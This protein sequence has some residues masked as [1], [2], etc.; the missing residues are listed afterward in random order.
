VK[1]W[2]VGSYPKT[3]PKFWYPN[4]S[5]TQKIITSSDINFEELNFQAT[6]LTEPKFQVEPNAQAYLLNKYSEDVYN[7]QY[8]LSYKFSFILF[9]LFLSC[10]R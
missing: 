5:G 2:V 3:E 8:L 1:V 6:E 7:W 10:N 4:F 9:W